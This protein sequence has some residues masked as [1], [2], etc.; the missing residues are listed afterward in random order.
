MKLIILIFI[1]LTPF[2][3]NAQTDNIDIKWSKITEEN[4]NSG[5]IRRMITEPKV[6]GY[7]DNKLFIEKTQR[8]SLANSKDYEYH[9]EV[10]DNSM[11]LI[12]EKEV[13]IDKSEEFHDLIFHNNKIYIING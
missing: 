12:K 9:L 11:N 8:N 5:L 13:L 10:Y 4:S 2:L 7:S 3:C 6:L 1:A